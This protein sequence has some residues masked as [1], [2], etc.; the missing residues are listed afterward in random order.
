MRSPCL[1]PELHFH[2]TALDRNLNQHEAPSLD[3]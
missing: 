2:L 1:F 3:Y